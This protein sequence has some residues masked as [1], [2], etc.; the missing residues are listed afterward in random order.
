MVGGVNEEYAGQIDLLPTLLHLLGMG[1]KN[2]VHFGTDLLSEQHD[3]VIPFRNGDFVSS[4]ITSVDG[5]FYDSKTG[6]ILASERL[7]EA[8]TYQM[9]AEQKLAYSDKVV[10]GDLLRF[11]TPD[12]F[13]PVDR[14]QYD[15]SVTKN[16]NLVE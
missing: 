14:S 7:E 9:V 10:N 16:K 6:E 15:Y 13:T 3:D 2:Y 5:V 12:H 11:Y 1:T 4:E 8:K